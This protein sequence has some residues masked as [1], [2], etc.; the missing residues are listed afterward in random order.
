MQVNRAG[1]F[2]CT[3][4]N[5][6][7]AVQSIL[8]KTGVTIYRSLFHDRLIVVREGLV[9]PLED[10]DL[11]AAWATVQQL[12]NGLEKVGKE[13]MLDALAFVGD[14]YA[15]D[16]MLDW[17]NGLKWDGVPRLH[18]LCERAFGVVVTEYHVAA[19][20]NVLVALVARQYEPGKQFDHALVLI[21]AQ[22]FKKTRAL[23]SLFGTE[24][25][26]CVPKDPTTK[27]SMLLMR[28]KLCVELDELAALRK[29]D[30]EQIKSWVTHTVDEYRDPYGRITAQHPRRFVIVGTTNTQ[31]FLEDDENRRWWPVTVGQIDID[32]LREQRDQ[33][34]AEA[35]VLHQAGHRFWEIPELAAQ[36]AQHKRRVIDP[37]VDVIARFIVEG[38]KY[39]D[40]GGV[41]HVRPFPHGFVLTAD[42]LTSWLGLSPAQL[43]GVTHSRMLATAMRAAGYESARQ[44]GPNNG[45]R[46]W[47][48]KEMKWDPESREWRDPDA[49]AF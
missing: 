31:E 41:E 2:C 17:L 9:R 30:V 8:D 6:A 29:S 11:R 22:G 4:P 37:W 1:N 47:V 7:S 28:G 39:E 45:Q 32:Y 36:E 43:R 21:S 44:D 25:V 48:P 20:K 46:G 18:T 24:Y 26:A 23:G 27:D 15:R 33:L 12:G 10:C 13:L 3:L 5:V 34:F 49:G 40:A 38:K 14:Y 42:L 35:V 19:F 16:E